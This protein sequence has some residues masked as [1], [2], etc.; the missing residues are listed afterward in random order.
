M[1]TNSESPTAVFP[2]SGLNAKFI[3]R[4]ASTSKSSTI[5]ASKDEPLYD[6]WYNLN[7]V[8]EVIAAAGIV[9]VAVIE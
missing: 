9:A 4:P 3:P 5:H 8:D 7:W 6:C 2:V 1:L